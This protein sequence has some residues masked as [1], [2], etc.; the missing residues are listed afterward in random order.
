MIEQRF[1]VE[2]HPDLERDPSTGAILVK[3][4]P[5]LAAARKKAKAEA[6]MRRDIETLFV[7]MDDL[8]T[9]MSTIIELL[10]GKV[11]R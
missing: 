1:E 3:Q 10:Q 2:G 9:K 5:Q 11:A 8:N 7:Q 4:S 6:S